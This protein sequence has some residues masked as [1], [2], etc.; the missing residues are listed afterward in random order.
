M[1]KKAMPTATLGVA[2]LLTGCES[3]PIPVESSSGWGREFSVLPT[4]GT[5]DSTVAIVDG[6]VTDH[7]VLADAVVGAW[8]AQPL[9]GLPRNSHGTEMAGLVLGVGSSENLSAQSIQILDVRVLDD[10]G[11][12]STEDIA[13]GVRWAVANQADL[14]LMSLSVS[15]HDE[16][17][18]AAVT[19]AIQA[20][21]IVVASTANGF[22]DTPSYPAEYPGVI[23]VTSVS[24][25][26]T[27]APLA[28]LRGADIAAPGDDVAV[29]SGGP[30]LRT[31][32]GTSAAAAAAASVVASCPSMRGLNELGIISYAKES[33]VAVA[34]THRS[35]PVLRCLT[36]GK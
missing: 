25:D 21:V 30:E 4:S 24:P 27:L 6:G 1:R 11:S 19:E 28:G 34:P 15:V 20:G 3:A 9:A 8:E 29:L 31:V 16:D 13:M 17:L 36:K 22:S 33:G 14:I 26:F 2:L 10:R 12:G 35:I 5:V 7:P 23:G 32:S 18:E